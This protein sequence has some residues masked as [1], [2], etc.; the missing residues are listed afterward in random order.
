[1]VVI[2]PSEE[3][4]VDLLKGLLANPSGVL[5]TRKVHDPWRAGSLEEGVDS[6]AVEVETS[7]NVFR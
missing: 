2:G 3:K 4:V 5:Q 6:S 1:M 7:A